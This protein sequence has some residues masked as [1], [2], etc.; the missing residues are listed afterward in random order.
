MAAELN[1]NYSNSARALKK[2]ERQGL[3]LVTRPG[4]GV[5]VVIQVKSI[6]SELIGISVPPDGSSQNR[7]PRNFSQS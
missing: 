5:P 7:G 3:A 4:P 6:P 2:L 1:I